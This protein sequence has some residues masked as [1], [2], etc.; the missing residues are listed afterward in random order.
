[1]IDPDL[2]AFIEGGVG[3]HI[4]SRTA[5][6]EPN[7]ARVT[8]VRVE[9]DLLHLLVYVP[10]VAASRVLPDLQANGAAAVVFARPID[11]RACQIKGIFAGLAAG[12]RRRAPLRR[13]AVGRVPGQSREDRHPARGRQRLDHLAVDG[14][15]A[16]APRP[17]SN[18]RQARRPAR[19][20]CRDHER[21][22][23][24]ARHVLPG[25]AAGAALHLL[26]GRSAECGVPQS[27]G[28][29]RFDA[30]GAVVPVLQQEPPQHH[31]EPAGARRRDRSRH[32]AGLEPAAEIRPLGNQRAAVR[33]DGAAHRSDRVLL[34]AQ[35]H[36]QAARGGRL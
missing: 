27:C 22:A 28:L 2:R 13:A 26:G 1:M 5:V 15:P 12:R 16:C 17:F 35:G 8:A 21:P 23:R 30:R 34:R 29:R 20:S 9:E 3:I 10:E 7:G 14:D 36:L 18:R 32:R 19:W 24:V 31:R 25:P 6:L 33:A 11:D 4:G